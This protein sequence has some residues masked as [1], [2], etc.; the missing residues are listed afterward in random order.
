MD[1]ICE[2]HDPDKDACG[3]PR[4]Q[5]DREAKHE[6]AFGL[7]EGKT[8]TETVCTNHYLALAYGLHPE[9]TA[10]GHVVYVPTEVGFHGGPDG[11]PVESVELTYGE[12]IET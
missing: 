7:P 3:A 2:M 9:T 10:D 8:K 1:M 4:D 6:M 11:E 5:D 12:W